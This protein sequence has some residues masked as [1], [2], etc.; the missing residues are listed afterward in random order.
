MREAE[1]R[2]TVGDLARQVN[3]DIKNG[4]IP[5]RNVM[6]HLSQVQRDDPAALPAVY[7]ERRQTVDSSIAYLEDA[8]HELR[9]AVPARH[10]SCRAI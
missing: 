1:H 2:A 3:H 10:P 9:A 8:G 4:L 5:L 7:A 6:R